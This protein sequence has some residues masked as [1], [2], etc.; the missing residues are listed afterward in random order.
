MV[1]KDKL[2]IL[3]VYLNKNQFQVES[4]KQGMVR[5]ITQKGAAGKIFMEKCRSKPFD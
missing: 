4:T 2:K 1:L 5:N 3:R